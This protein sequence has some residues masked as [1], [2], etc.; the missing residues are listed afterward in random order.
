MFECF[1][2]CGDTHVESQ[3][4]SRNMSFL[5][6]STW[7]WE[8]TPSFLKDHCFSFPQFYITLLL[9]V[10]VLYQGNVRHPRR[11]LKAGPRLPAPLL[12]LG[13]HPHVEAHQLQKLGPKE[14]GPPPGLITGPPL[15]SNSKEWRSLAGLL[16][17]RREEVSTTAE[18][19]SVQ[20]ASSENKRGNWTCSATR[21]TRSKLNSSAVTTIKDIYWGTAT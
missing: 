17:L 2:C 16:H 14:L 19:K 1:V 4:H 3:A 10:P 13:L 12:L 20:T 7:V 9:P 15:L 21:K 18:R 5:N 8:N 6:F 11:Q